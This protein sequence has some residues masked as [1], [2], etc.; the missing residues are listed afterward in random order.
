MLEEFDIKA[1]KVEDLRK[2][3]E[4]IEKMPSVKTESQYQSVFAAVDKITQVMESFS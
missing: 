3:K 4:K 1:L 2:L